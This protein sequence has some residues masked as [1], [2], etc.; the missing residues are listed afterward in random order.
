MAFFAAVSRGALH[1]QVSPSLSAEQRSEVIKSVV[2][3]DLKRVLVGDGWTSRERNH[4]AFAMP[5]NSFL[6]TGLK[7]DFRDGG[8]QIQHAVAGICIGFDWG[9]PA[10]YIVYKYEDGEEDRH[11]YD[12]TFEL[13]KQLRRIPIAFWPSKIK[14]TLLA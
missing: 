13:G 1:T 2:L 6:D 5:F 7:A 3:H 9:W 12:A 14:S 8:N 10:T 4:G 11:L